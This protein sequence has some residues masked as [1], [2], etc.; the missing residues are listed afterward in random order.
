MTRLSS[1]L[2]A[3]AVL[4]LTGCETSEPAPESPFGTESYGRYMVGDS[5]TFDNPVL[6]WTVVS[7]EGERVYWRSDKGDEQVTGHDPLLPALEWKNPGKGGGRR[8]I[9][10]IKGSL[11][12]LTEPGNMTFTSNVENWTIKDG[13]ATPPQKWEYNWSC[14]VAGQE[15]VEVP[16][17]T[18]ETY[19]VICGRY[20]PSELE[21]YYSPEIGHY[22]VM[23]IDDPANESTI[24]RNLISFRRMALL[25]PDAVPELPPEPEM[26]AP[27][28]MP[29]APPE[30]APAPPPPPPQTKELAPPPPPP[31]YSG[32]SG[33]RAVLGA[34]STEENAVRAWSIY[35]RE[36][37]DVLGGLEPQIKP[38]T[39]SSQGTLFRLAT[40]RLESGA[41][42]KEMC[43]KI[44]SR[45]G[46]CFVSTK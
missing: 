41:T 12:P 15:T 3:L 20:K 32:G 37:G 34:F 39:F 9:S 11:F 46:E 26:E 28:A 1:I 4:L 33:P 35:R 19:R 5:F 25:G 24:T 21:F 27:A 40:Q 23:R 22:V 31:V 36:Y 10:D 30:P 8:V 44:R 7:V 18:F 6:T 14:K 43:R 17:G 38:V 45:G 42:A 13:Q 29:A 2:G 16:A